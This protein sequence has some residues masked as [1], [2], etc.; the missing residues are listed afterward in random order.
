MTKPSTEPD[1]DSDD[2]G[3]SSAEKP[4][5][6]YAKLYADAETTTSTDAQAS[7]SKDAKASAHALPEFKYAVDTYVPKMDAAAKQEATAYFLKKAR[8]EVP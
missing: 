5:A 2:A 3:G 8:V 4:K 1:A 7:T 6:A